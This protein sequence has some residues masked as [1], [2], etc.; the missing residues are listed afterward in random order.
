MEFQED[1][2]RDIA[3]M[4]QNNDSNREPYRLSFV[5][6]YLLCFYLFGLCVYFYAFPL[7][8]C[9]Y[10]L[11]F[12]TYYS[13]IVENCLIYHLPIFLKAHIKI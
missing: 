13:H 1:V 2:R 11:I 5:F 10:A 12:Y 9:S 7:F 6:V 4:R 8:I 3:Y